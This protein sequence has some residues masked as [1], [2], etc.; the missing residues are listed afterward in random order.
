VVK[1]IVALQSN[2]E[3]YLYGSEGIYTLNI[4]V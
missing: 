1:F 3:T 2:R 4:Y